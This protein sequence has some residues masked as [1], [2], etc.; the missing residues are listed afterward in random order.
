MVWHLVEI[1]WPRNIFQFI[2][3]SGSW[4]VLSTKLIAESGGTTASAYQIAIVVFFY[5]ASLG[6]EQWAATLVGQNPEAK[7]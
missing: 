5:P 1:A 2:I 7:T 3:A 4:I 6:P